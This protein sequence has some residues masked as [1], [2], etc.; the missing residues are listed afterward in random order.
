MAIG[1][2]GL[3]AIPPD[4]AEVVRQ[5][6]VRADHLTMLDGVGVDA[7]RRAVEER[8]GMGRLNDKSTAVVLPC[9]CGHVLLA[10]EAH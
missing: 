9:S 6:S 1:S 4:G 7:I 8:K 10:R 5:A 2:D 3:H